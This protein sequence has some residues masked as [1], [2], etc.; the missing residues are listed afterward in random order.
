MR[1]LFHWGVSLKIGK[2]VQGRGEERTCTQVHRGPQTRD[3]ALLAIFRA[4]LNVEYRIAAELLLAN[5]EKRMKTMSLPLFLPMRKMRKTELRIDR[6]GV[7]EPGSI[8]AR[9]DAI[10]YN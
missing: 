4:A 1:V 9:S 6:E 8:F 10:P 3:W 2:S 7:L 5:A